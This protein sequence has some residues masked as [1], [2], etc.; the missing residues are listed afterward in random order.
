MHRLER[1]PGC[2]A[3]Y[4]RYDGATHPYI[5]A[6]AA[7]WALH[8]AVLSGAE[9]PP[10]LLSASDVAAVHVRTGAPAPHAGT[11]LLDAYAAQHHGSPSPQA[12][13]SVAV[14]LLVLHGVLARGVS[15]DAALWIR[16]RAVRRKGVFEWL[17]PPD[18][19]RAYS[20]RHCF[21][22]KEM[23]APCSLANYVC[24]VHEA[25][26]ARHAGQLDRWYDAY[27]AT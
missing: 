17:T 10:E 11:L 20:L 18:Q 19:E 14:H 8:S 13:Q 15:A 2:A 9:P 12:I 5:G 26:Q 1:C 4:P 21:P 22:N 24:S 23:D 27:V 25:W 6:S 16:R 3:S 7:C